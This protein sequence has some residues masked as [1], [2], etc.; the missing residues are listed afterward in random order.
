MYRKEQRLHSDSTRFHPSVRP[1]YHYR[2]IKAWI[3]SN[4]VGCYC[5][6]TITVLANWTNKDQDE[7]LSVSVTSIRSQWRVIVDYF[8]RTKLIP[9]RI[10][11]I[12]IKYQWHYHQETLERVLSRWNWKRGFPKNY[13]KW[14][15]YWFWL[16]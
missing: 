6:S 9:L 13:I 11:I 16:L 4:L 2:C 15:W 14:R 1:S 7:S 12:Q 3:I 10:E 8:K 5:I